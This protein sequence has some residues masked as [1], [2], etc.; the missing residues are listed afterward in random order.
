MPGNSLEHGDIRFTVDDEPADVLVVLNYLKYDTTISARSGYVWNWHNEPIVRKPFAKG[1]DRVFSHEDSSDPRVVQA[2]PILDW[3]VE[4][5]WDELARLEP[6][7]KTRGLSLIASDKAMIPGHRKRREF[8]SLVEDCMPEVDVFG[9][10]RTRQLDDKWDGLAPYK[11]SVAIENTSKFGYWTEKIAD[12]FL[13]FTVPVYFGATNIGEYFPEDSF[14]WLP[15]D[16]TPRA[17]QLLESAMLKDSW[18]S[19]LPAVRQAR[20]LVLDQYSLYGQLSN[21]I[22]NERNLIQNTPVITVKVQGRRI[23]PG[24][25]VRNAGLR[26]N[27]EVQLSRL[28]CR[29]AKS[30]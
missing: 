11:F 25:W 17:I 6:P 19:R 21:R 23:R 14:I 12:C 2:P 24:G 18:E 13:S 28:L 10:G 30:S 7:K 29:L 22:R 4:K 20:S 27:L 5:S 26:T 3:W 15:L 9:I 8:V 16:D 1:F